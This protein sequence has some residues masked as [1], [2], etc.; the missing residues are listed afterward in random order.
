MIKRYNNLS[1]AIA[2]PGIILQ[3]AG[4]LLMNGEHPLL[5]SVM[6]LGGTV[7]VMVGFAYYAMAKGRSPA[8]CL[9]G[10]FSCLGLLMLG[11]LKDHSGV[12]EV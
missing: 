7:M 10:F 4:Q 5:G 6:A 3:V 11:L 8:W 2:I 1:L 9:A 12:D